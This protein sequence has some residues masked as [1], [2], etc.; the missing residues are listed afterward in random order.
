MTRR[1]SRPDETFH[2]ASRR[3]AV[4]RSAMLEGG[5]RKPSL[6]NRLLRLM[7]LKKRR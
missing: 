2:R 1:P 5:A 3:K 7:G 4:D 6:L